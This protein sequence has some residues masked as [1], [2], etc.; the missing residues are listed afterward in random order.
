MTAARSIAPV[1]PH[2][3]RTPAGRSNAPYTAFVLSGGASLG[4][5]HVGMLRALYERGIVADVLVATGLGALNAAFVASRP[6]T[7]AT[8]GELARVWCGIQREDVF[9]VSVRTL[10][11]G[12]SGQ[13]DHLVSDLALRRQA[14][15][16]IEFEDL[17]EAPV[18]LHLLAFDV[19]EGREQL[20]SDGPALDSIAAAAALPGVFPP[21]PIG[22]RRLIDGSVVNNTPISHAVALGAE[23]I[24]ILPTQ[25]RWHPLGRAPYGALDAAIYGIGLHVDGRL[26][27]D[28][29]RYSRDAELIALPAPNSLPVQP[30]DFD[31]AGRLIGEAHTA[32]RV[33]LDRD[34]AAPRHLSLIASDQDQG[35]LGRAS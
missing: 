26:R 16:Y 32:S 4:A 23:R 35:V 18:P 28:I 33:L 11:G 29:A 8:A 7:P 22:E 3:S 14:R 17:A 13:R 15:R 34:D 27:A 24:Y 20:L 25:E 5:L 19:I 21:V 31:H 10:V 9:P 2:V 6:Q 12:F 1:R 30:T